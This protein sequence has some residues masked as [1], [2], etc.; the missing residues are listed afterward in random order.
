MARADGAAEIISTASEC[1]KIAAAKHGGG[2]I[3]EPD[4]GTA[5]A[6]RHRRDDFEILQMA[7]RLTEGKMIAP[8]T[9]A[10]QPIRRG[11]DGMLT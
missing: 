9:D 1:A 7:Q 10:M 2:R 4:R 8:V 3:A 6:R 11:D 5:S